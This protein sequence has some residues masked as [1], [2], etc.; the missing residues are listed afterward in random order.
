MWRSNPPCQYSWRGARTLQDCHRDCK[1]SEGPL[2]G[3]TADSFQDAGAQPDKPGRDAHGKDTIKSGG[4]CPALPSF[5][6]RQW[7]SSVCRDSCPEGISSLKSK[8]FI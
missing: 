1:R 7:V 3:W 8:C 2:W 5:L 6:P 4:G